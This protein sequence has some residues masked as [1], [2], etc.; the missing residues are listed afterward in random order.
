[1]TKER[2]REYRAISK[3]DMEA[4]L[5][6]FKN[7]LMQLRAAAKTSN[8]AAKACK[9]RV[10]RKCIARVLT[11]LNQREKEN[12]RKFYAE[13]QNKRLTPKYLKPKLTRAKR[14]AL[15][16]AQKNAK[17]LKRRKA[18]A[19]FPKRMYYIKM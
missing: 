19:A 10:I 8:Q 17:T 3:E 18:E 2:A 16:T 6:G 15:T 12:V 4:K 5:N 13:P 14:R 1:M 7:E 9:Q 11:V